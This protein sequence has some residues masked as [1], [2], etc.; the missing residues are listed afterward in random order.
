VDKD[1][2]DRI[3]GATFPMGRRGYEKREVDRFLNRLADWLET[4]GGDEA[5]AD[6][7]RRELERVGEQTG[8][9][10]TDAHEAAEKLRTGAEAEARASV[11]Q[12]TG[13]A[14][15]ARSE[16]DA[17]SERTRID[18]DAYSSESRDEADAYTTRV[19]EE[20]DAYAGRT[21]A[22]A[23]DYAAEKRGQI[24][25][26]VDEVQ[27]QAEA[28]AAE[29]RASAERDASTKL[30][31]AEENA[32]TALAEAGRRQQELDAEIA[33][34]ET[35]RTAVLEDMQRLSSE[36][37]GTASQHRPRAERRTRIIDDEDDQAVEDGEPVG[38]G[39]RTAGP[40]SGGG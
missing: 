19:R 22:A 28:E 14:E 35:R 39:E 37:T 16:A 25:D 5:R 13:A 32:I 36:L 31:E 9:I 38:S 34:L 20:A 10:L 2:I 21:R 18:A 15:K 12:V 7:V 30:A 27:R 11:E 1:S 26:H 8:K 4:G 23:D 6:L 24:D 17:Y 40:A 3:R 29:I 33:D